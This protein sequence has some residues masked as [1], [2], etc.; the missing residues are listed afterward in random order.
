MPR[1]NQGLR[2]LRSLQT[3]VLNSNALTA[4]G[5]IPTLPAL[6]TLHLNDNKLRSLVGITDLVNLTVRVAV[7]RRACSRVLSGGGGCV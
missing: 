3:L 1:F 4:L 6:E 5:E 7:L 2:Y